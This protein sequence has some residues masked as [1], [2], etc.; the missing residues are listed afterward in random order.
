MPTDNVVSQMDS[1]YYGDETFFENKAPL[2]QWSG[3]AIVVGFGVFFSFVTS[4]IV[5][6]EAKFTGTKV[7][8]EFFN[9]AGRDIKIGLT[10]SVI[11]SQWTWAA[12]LLQS[13]NVAWQFG[14]S[15][16]FWYASGATIQ[17]L[18]FGILAIELKR[19]APTCHTVC[20]LVL[21]RWGKTAHKTFIFFSF[22]TSI[23]VTSMLLLGGSATMKALAGCDVTLT[24]FLIPW[25]VILYTAA[26][27]LKATFL[28]SYIHTGVI[29]VILLVM[30]YTVY[31]KEYSTD[32]IYDLLEKTIDH[33]F[34]ECEIIFSENYKCDSSG[35]SCGCEVDGE[36]SIENCFGDGGNDVSETFYDD[37]FPRYACG[38]VK[39]NRRGSYLTMLSAPGLVFG[40][41]NIIGNFG[42]VFVDQSY[43][44]SAIA[45]K[46][47]AAHKGYMLGGMVWFTIPFALATACGLAAV[48]LQLPIDA[49]EAS[50][51]LVPPAVAT[52]VYGKTGALMISIML[53]MAIVSTGSAES[54]AVASIAAYDVYRTYFNP[55]ATGADIMRVSRIVVVVY[56]LVM[57]VLAVILNA[58]G[59]SLGWVYLFMG[60]VIGSAVIPL[61]NLMTWEN[62][63]ARG[64]V[65]AAWGG[66]ILALITWFVAASIAGGSI[67]IATLGNNYVMLAA[68]VVA[69]CSS[70][71]IHF[72]HSKLYPQNY[73]WKSMAEIQLL[74][75]DRSGLSDEDL[76][77]IK[78]EEA[79]AWI[80]KVGWGFTILIVVV[81]PVLSTPA[82]VFTKD[83]FA[84]WVFIALLWGLTASFIIVFLPIYESKNSIYL[85]LDGIF[86]TSLSAPIVPAAFAKTEQVVLKTGGPEEEEEEEENVAA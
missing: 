9:T 53:F 22:L 32:E 66:M 51:G 86:G 10:A 46:P 24:S 65:F 75:N 72:V 38:S 47:A 69:I 85:V 60:I 23:I 63:S 81:W 6:L 62:A 54:I 77:P 4:G 31:V 74:D 15:G 36:I 52:H 1:K 29:F 28:A 35:T 67:S 25:G 59:L 26:G 83:Y 13:S 34:E 43:W 37:D 50:K 79:K 41:I 68:N 70:G 21:V 16:P 8:S 71:C 12:T 14:V 56:G 5:W 48:A 20:E 2:P 61:W 40:I 30:V 33:S 11:V 42:T 55:E 39:G 27:G 80:A 45:A 19:R 3:Y 64:A 82:G 7:T 84:F 78:L 76:D 44:Q 17:V 73:D 58:I 18:L 49:E 57:G